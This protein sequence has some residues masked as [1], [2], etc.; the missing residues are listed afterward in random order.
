M[1]SF[2]RLTEAPIY[3]GNILRLYPFIASTGIVLWI[4]V[5]VVYLQRRTPFL[6]QVGLLEFVAF[7]QLAVSE[8]PTGT[9]PLGTHQ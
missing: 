9:V 5:R 7:V 4:P 2:P 3:Q 8:V 1:A 6:S